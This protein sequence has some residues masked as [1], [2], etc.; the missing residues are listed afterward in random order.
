VVFIY[1]IT[2]KINGKV[3]IGQ[4]CKPIK[5][6]WLRH[7]HSTSGCV[8]LRDAIAEYGVDS[9]L[10]EEVEV[11]QNSVDAMNRECYWIE[12]YDSMNIGYNMKM[13]SLILEETR[14][15]ISEANK[16]W[17]RTEETRAKMSNTKKGRTLSQ[18]H[19][20]KIGEAGKKRTASEETRAKMSIAKKG[21]V[22]S[23]ETKDKLSKINTGNVISEE[24]R[25]KISSSNKGK[26][27]KPHKDDKAIPNRVP[28]MAI[29]DGFGLFFDSI[30]AAA[31]QLG[32][33]ASNVSIAC[34]TGSRCG[35]YE[36]QYIKG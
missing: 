20:D 29:G 2:N 8:R 10:V 21:R 7:Q 1:K 30:A 19:K 33:H 35:G 14:K 24:T 9:F 32:M 5:H 25:A 27:S 34:K 36:F 17:V 28:V 13:G 16:T 12:F 18:E 11:C 23:Q 6:R 31:R 26:H 15:K 3:Y 4:T 22:V